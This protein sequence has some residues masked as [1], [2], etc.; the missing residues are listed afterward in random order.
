MTVKDHQRRF[1]CLPRMSAFTPIA[2]KL[3]NYAK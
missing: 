1:E 3:L 2:A